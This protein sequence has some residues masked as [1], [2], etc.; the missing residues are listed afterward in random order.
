MDEHSN[1]VATPTGSE[2][3]VKSPS[4]TKDESVCEDKDEEEEMATPSEGDIDSVIQQAATKTN[5]SVLNVK[6][7]LHVRSYYQVSNSLVYSTLAYMSLYI[8]VEY[9]VSSR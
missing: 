9:L 4:G 1:S 5:L 8:I 3:D 2:E 6:S 7:I